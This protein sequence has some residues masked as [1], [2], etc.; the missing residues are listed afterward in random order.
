MGDLSLDPLGAVRDARRQRATLAESSHRPW[1]LPEA[2][3]FMGQTWRH[4]L[5]A[6]WRVDPDRLRRVVPGQL[7]LDLRDGAAWIG[8]TPFRVQGVRLRGT[9]PPPLLSRFPELNVRTYVTL[10]GKP[11]IYFLSLDAASRA[12]VV[13]ARRTY[14]LPYFRSRMSLEREGDR[15]RLR[16]RRLSADGPGATFDC[17]YFPAGEQFRAGPGSIEEFLAERY[18]LYTFDPSEAVH[19]ADIH[20]PPWPLQPARAEVLENSMLD[21]LGIAVD[22]EP[23]LHFAHRQDVVLWPIAPR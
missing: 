18:C 13:S 6:H 5:F 21:G 23:L 8:V 4:L 9:L 2:G 16:S 11:G 20:H 19:R 17:R 10:D 7:A 22:G 14:R 12:A 1:P 15:F 3:W